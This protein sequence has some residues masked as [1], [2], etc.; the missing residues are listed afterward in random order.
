MLTYLFNVS[1]A[2]VSTYTCRY[3]P[4]QHVV[5]SVA[6]SGVVTATPAEVRT[7]RRRDAGRASVDII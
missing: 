2:N 6:G 5:M 1:Y 3:P 4:G 7:E